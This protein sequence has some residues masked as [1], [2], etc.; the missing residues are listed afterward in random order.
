MSHIISTTMHLGY[1]PRLTSVHTHTLSASTPCY[2][3]QAPGMDPLRTSVDNITCILS[4]I[5]FRL[6]GPSKQAQV[7]SI[8]SWQS[9]AP[10]IWSAI[11]VTATYE[12]TLALCGTRGPSWSVFKHKLPLTSSFVYQLEQWAL[13]YSPLSHNL[14]VCMQPMF[15]CLCWSHIS[16]KWQVVHSAALT[17]SITSSEVY[18]LCLHGPDH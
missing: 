8:H 1:K 15:R 11:K 17:R 13:F 7:A 3:Q 18:M 9:V 5:A 14:H 10:V 2:L 12:A 6:I 16:S 4:R